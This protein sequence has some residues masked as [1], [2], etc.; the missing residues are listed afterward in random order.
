[1]N[2]QA[3]DPPA[4]FPSKV[5]AETA[6]DISA[7]A[8]SIAPWIGVPISNILGGISTGRKLSRV[9][10]CLQELGRQI[11]A[12]HDEAAESF[13]KTEDFE[14]LLEETLR[15][16]AMER[17]E[18][19][20]RLYGD[21]LVNNVGCPDLEYERRL[22]LLKTLENTQSS[23]IA[24]LKALAQPPTQSEVD[25]SMGSIGETLRSRL[26]DVAEQLNTI[27]EELERLDLASNL[28]KSLHTMMTARG[29]A[30]LHN[31]ISPFGREFM[32]FLAES[33]EESREGVR[34][35]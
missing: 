16:V 23:H 12:V 17:N 5:P 26:P 6:L 11:E 3:T 18:E 13:V 27:T 10:T 35:E 29:A 33:G 32:E 4:D 20:R 15:R 31:R 8:A 14:D 2:G 28:A 1:M 22:K 34:R 25:R 21:F 7:T 19:K 9:N 30:E 24:V